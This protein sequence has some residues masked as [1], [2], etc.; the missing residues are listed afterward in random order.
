MPE[1]AEVEYFRKVWSPGLGH[2]V[3]RV[4]LHPLARVFRDTSTELIR[5]KLPS[6]T[7]EASF[8][9]GKNLLFQFSGGNWLGGHLGMTGS[10]RVETAGFPAGKHDHLVLGFD[11]MSLVFTDPRM[12]GRIR[13]EVSKEGPPDWWRELPPEVLSDA[14]TKERVA[15]FLHRHRK[16]P[17][18]TLLLDQAA[19]PGIGNWMADEICWRLRWHPARLSGDV[20]AK[21]KTALWK[22]V[23]EVARDALRVIGPDW[24]EPPDSWLFNHRWDRD[25][26]CPRRGCGT[27]LVRAA[28]RGR[29]TCH[30]PRCQPAGDLRAPGSA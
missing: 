16:T 22:M 25:H 8:A 26:R 23:R 4:D 12:F 3:R 1:L 30:C 20:S 24:G 28:L 9:H 14:F 17:I 15:D 21:E 18:K 6:A 29:T 7:F 27:L 13:F 5:R 2:A 10:L 11:R 19:F